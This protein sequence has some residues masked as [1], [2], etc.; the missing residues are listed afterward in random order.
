MAADDGVTQQELVDRLEP[1]LPDGSEALTGAALTD[2]QRS[3]L[4]GD[5]LGFFKAFLLV[6]A[7]IALVVATFSIY[8]TFSILVAQR[9]RESAC[10]GPW[11]VSRQVLGSTVAEALA[12][13]VLASA[14]GVAAGVGLA[15]GLE[16][17]SRVGGA[18][19]GRH[20]PGGGD[21]GTRAGR[22][23]RRGGHAGRQRRPGRQGLAV[24]PGGPAG[25]RRRPVGR[26]VVRG[27][28][29]V[30]VAGTGIAATV[31]GTA[32]GFAAHDRAALPGGSRLRAPRP[33]GGSPVAGVVGG[34]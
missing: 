26:F 10:C 17:A 5:F 6:F 29:G 1:A 2:E 12:V 23:R 25:R 30:V 16:R 15:A 19:R 32:G 21:V 8:N 34:R 28:L 24:A 3:E 9:T 4:E 14:I 18:C 7:G 22:G 33:G 27:L 20:R 11:G 13:G 31:G